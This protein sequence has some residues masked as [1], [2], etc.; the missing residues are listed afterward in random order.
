M[1][2]NRNKIKEEF[3]GIS[4]TELSKKLGERW[5]DVKDK[6][7]SMMVKL[8]TMIFYLNVNISTIYPTFSIFESVSATC[9]ILLALHIINNTSKT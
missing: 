8:A 7:V 6:S 3:P 1:G 2:E 9:L 5:K 4:V